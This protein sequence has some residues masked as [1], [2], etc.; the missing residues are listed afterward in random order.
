[1]SY[2]S[3]VCKEAAEKLEKLDIDAEVI[4]LMSLSPLDEQIIIES[5]SKTNRIVI[6]DED[7]PRA[8]WLAKLQQLYLT[9]HLT[10]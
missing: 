9:R 10:I 8:V 7:N 6:V 5:V 3:V 1:M 2:T 4:D